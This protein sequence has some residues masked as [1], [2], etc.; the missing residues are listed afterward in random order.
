MDMDVSISGGS[1]IAFVN[2]DVSSMRHLLSL[3]CRT[4]QWSQEFADGVKFTK[5]PVVC[6]PDVTEIQLKDDDEFVLVASDGLW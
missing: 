4:E 6:D 2:L 1:W 3:A 5:D